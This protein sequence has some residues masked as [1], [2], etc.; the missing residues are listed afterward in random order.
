MGVFAYL[1][2]NQPWFIALSL[3]VFLIFFLFRPLNSPQYRIIVA[4]G[5]GYYSYLPAQFIHHDTELKFEWFDKVFEANYDNHLFEKP[6]Q[7]FMVKYGDRMINLY[8]PGQSLLQAPFFFVAH[9][10]AKLLDY[11]TDGFSLPYQLAIGIS[12]L[13]YTLLGLFFCHQL[14]FKLSQ[15]KGLSILI[16]L[17]V[18]F[19][20]NLF[21][22]S[23]FAGCYTHCYSFCFLSMSLFFSERFFNASEHKFQSLLPLI[24]CAIVVITLRPMNGILLLSLLYFFKPFSLKELLSIKKLNVRTLLIVFAILLVLV[25]SV[26]ILYTQTHSL[27]ANTYT[28]GKFYFNDWSHVYDNFLGFQNG[29]L[30]YTPL[31]FLCFIPLL[32][33][34]KN[35]KVL[36][37]LLP[38][39]T[40]I[41]LYSFWFYWNI[42]NR[43][44]V[45][46][47]AILALLL[48]VLYN[49]LERNKGL[50]KGLM[51]TALLAVPFYQLKA[52]Q[53]RNGILNNNYTTWHYYLKYFF[54]LHHVDV[55]PV[56]PNTILIEETH[57]FD[58][59]ND[60]SPEISTVNKFEGQQSLGLTKEIEY[61]CTKTYTLPEFYNRE[62]FKKVKVSFWFYRAEE[63]TNTQLILSFAQKDSV[64]SY[65]P[66]YIN[67]STPAG[68]WELK[69]FGLDLPEGLNSRNTLT[70][71]FWN[72]EKKGVAYIDNL[73]LEFILKDGSDEIKLEGLLAP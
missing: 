12:G 69:E 44:L 30:W 7:N 8:Y 24:F 43:T 20:T 18:F 71:Y 39:L 14:I 5:L 28:I 41:L 3:S 6:S 11:P 19:G 35:P 57:Y 10:M 27:F 72:P 32:F 54:T 40:V 33:V 45:D 16:P 13:F 64:I 61:A 68:K 55:F 17:L 60:S 58:F 4:D 42:V 2:K 51:I 63:M 49:E 38:V 36:F 34:L 50:Q 59:E 53:L 73:K 29:I 26:R 70:L 25:Y 15:N 62:G 22:Y 48:L 47:T 1:K 46:F 67:T 37:L 21:T 23:I 52:Y 31:I 56:N 66:F 9:A 65:N